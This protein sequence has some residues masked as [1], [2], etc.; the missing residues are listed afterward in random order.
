MDNLVFCQW[1]C[2]SAIANKAN[3]EYLLNENKV[4]IALLS[5]TWF[6]PNSSITFP[7]YNIIRKDRLDGKGGVAI[8]I[9]TNIKFIKIAN[10]NFENIFYT[11]IRIPLKDRSELTLVSVYVNPQSRVSVQTWNSFFSSF[12]SP[13]LFCGDFNAHHVTWG[14]N[15][16]NIQGNVLLEALDQCNLIFLIDGSFTR[17]NPTGGNNSAID[18]SLTSPQLSSI[19]EWTILD[20]TYGSDHV[21]ILIK[22]KVNAGFT[23]SNDFK[24][25]KINQANWNSYYTECL[26]EF[27]NINNCSYELFV[28]KL[29]NVSEKSIPLNNQNKNNISRGKPWW[30]QNCQNVVNKRKE[31]YKKYKTNPNSTNLIEYKKIDALAKKTLKEAK[32]EQWRKYCSSL[33]KNTPIG[34]VWQ[35]VNRFKNRRRENKTLISVDDPWIEEFQGKLAPPYISTPFYVEAPNNFQINQ[36]TRRFDIHELG[37]VLKKNNNSAP[38]KDIIHYS[39]LSNIP[40]VA[41]LLLLDNSR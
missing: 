2:R 40:V 6:K 3:L 37:R 4:H 19:L 1:N 33:N 20:D 25:W 36:I 10:P 18:L 27:S 26:Q 17:I 5:E 29:N 38:G 12:H 28:E 13:V 16:S 21:P 32:R 14:C 15:D 22:C 24:K 41:K 9:K 35:Q 23:S 34:K 31:T 8:L 11:A 7:G 30:N 39:M